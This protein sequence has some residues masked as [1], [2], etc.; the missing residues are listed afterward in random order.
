MPMYGLSNELRLNELRFCV[1][2]AWLSCR[3][4]VHR[5]S[6]MSEYLILS[7]AVMVLINQKNHSNVFIILKTPRPKS[8]R[9]DDRGRRDKETRSDPVK[10]A[11]AV[12]ETQNNRPTS[13]QHRA[14]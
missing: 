12:L 11:R 2:P 10:S 6:C 7:H 13:A 4:Q 14:Q 1:V 9:I 5:V 3:L 8:S